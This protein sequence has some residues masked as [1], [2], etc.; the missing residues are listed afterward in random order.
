MTPFTARQP[1][2]NEALSAFIERTA[3]AYGEEAEKEKALAVDGCRRME[4]ALA[5]IAEFDA[6]QGGPIAPRENPTS[7]GMRRIAREALGR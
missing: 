1:E 4:E 3:V 2:T 5:Q 6:F 7:L